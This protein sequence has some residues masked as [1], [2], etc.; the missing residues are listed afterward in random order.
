[1]IRDEIKPMNMIQELLVERLITSYWRLRR[2]IKV[3]KGHIM[4]NYVNEYDFGMF[5][6]QEDY[7][8]MEKAKKEFNNMPN[9][10]ILDKILRYE[11]TLER[12]FYRALKEIEKQKRNEKE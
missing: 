9:E 6:N 12:Q 10:S 3:E 11:T 8:L 4:K 7:K 5:P 1:M 2:A